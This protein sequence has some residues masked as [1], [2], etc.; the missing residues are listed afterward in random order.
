LVLVHF[1]KPLMTDL[2]GAMKEYSE[3]VIYEKLADLEHEFKRL[4]QGYLVVNKRCAPDAERPDELFDRGDKMRGIRGRK[5]R[6]FSSQSS[7]GSQ[8]SSRT[9]R[10]S[11]DAD[12]GR[13]GSSNKR[14][15]D[16]TKKA[17]KMANVAALAA[18]SAK[19]SW[20]RA[21]S[22]DS[23][24]ACSSVLIYSLSACSRS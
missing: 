2:E 21:V 7:G 5:I 9:V 23:M 3:K 20:S 11:A 22:L 17:V 8:G 14:A 13:S 1:G 16:A 19:K 12:G 10:G 15:T 6:P 24:L 4:R 18:R